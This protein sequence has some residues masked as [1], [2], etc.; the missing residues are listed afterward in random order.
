MIPTGVSMLLYQNKRDSVF[1]CFQFLKKDCGSFAYKTVCGTKIRRDVYAYENNGRPCR[2]KHEYETDEI[3]RCVSIRKQSVE[4]I[5][6]S[7]SGQ[8]GMPVTL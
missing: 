8:W 5:R 2:G 7:W 1:P 4:E 3:H 6:L